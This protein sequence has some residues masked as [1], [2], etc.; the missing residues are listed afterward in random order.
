VKK[1]IVLIVVALVVAGGWYW[2]TAQPKSDSTWQTYRNEE[3]G[4]EFKY[5]QEWFLLPTADYLNQVR[6]ASYEEDVPCLGGVDAYAACNGTLLVWQLFKDDTGSNFGTDY[7]AR[8]EPRW[9]VNTSSTFM[10]KW[11]GDGDNPYVYK[12]FTIGD[13]NAFKL[14]PSNGYERGDYFLSRGNSGL[15]I[16]VHQGDDK[17]TSAT[18]DQIFST[19]KFID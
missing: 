10:A 1:T 6:V 18:V 2:Y 19:F 17:K 8:Q 5:P 16:S 13:S 3:Y 15:R 11:G 14:L 9:N 12:P 7:Y 4:F